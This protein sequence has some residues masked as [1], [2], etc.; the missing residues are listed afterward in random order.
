MLRSDQSPVPEGIDEVK[1]WVDANLS[2]TLGGG[3]VNTRSGPGGSGWAQTYVLEMKK[4][5]KLF[6]KLAR[7]RDKQMFE[8]EYEGLNAMEGTGAI[9]VPKAFHYD[10]LYGST[11]GS[12]ILMDFVDMYG[13]LDQAKLGLALGLM[14]SAEPLRDEAV[15]G[16]FGFHVENTIGA[17]PQPNGWMDSWVDFYRERRLLHQLKLTQDSKLLRLGDKA[18]ERMDEVFGDL[19]VKPSILHGD[20]WSGNVAADKNGKPVIFDPACY[21]GHHEAEFGMSWCANFTEHFWGAYREIIPQESGFKERLQLYKL[22]HYLNHL[23]L[24]GGSYYYQCESILKQ[25]N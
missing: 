6:A 10:D 23:N 8:G 3:V 9:G 19:E 5:G 25:F 16:S 4:G 11:S 17:T 20:L 2:R 15:E 7:G 1:L 14:H 21:Y 12:W 18:L 22:Y 24:F 13:S